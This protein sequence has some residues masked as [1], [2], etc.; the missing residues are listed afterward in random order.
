M[1][2][3]SSVIEQRLANYR[4]TLDDAIAHRSSRSGSGNAPADI[5]L[6]D[7]DWD[8]AP[9]GRRPD[10]SR[11]LVG[12][13]AVALIAG[14]GVFLATRTQEPSTAPSSAPDSLTPATA[15]AAPSNDATVDTAPA[16]IVPGSGVTPAC[17]AGTETVGTGTLYLGGPASDQNLATNGFIFS[18]PKGPTP[19][20]FAIKAIAL[21]V[22]G[23][24][25]SITAIPTANDN[26][27]SVLV[28]PPAVP[29]P[30]QLDVTIS[31]TDDVIGVTRIDGATTFEV[32]TTAPTPSLRLLD[33]VPS[34]AQ[35]VQVRFKKGD[36]VWELSADPKLGTDIPLTVP[37]GETDNFSNDPI[38]WVVFTLIGANERTVGAGGQVL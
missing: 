32:T 1:N 34:S 13:V 2:R 16:E 38:D 31:E 5:D 14:L 9:L 21:P 36:D 18:L 37:S 15:S 27:V 35:R 17:P 25:C 28:D 30:L 7:A 24:E 29:A 12:A 10:R 3:N 23:L 4:P 8:T 6:V 11:L 26:V 22:I 33:G 19:V 20:D